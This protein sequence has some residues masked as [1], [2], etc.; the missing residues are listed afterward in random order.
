MDKKLLL[1]ISLY[2]V[3]QAF[4]FHELGI[5]GEVAM[6]WGETPDVW[7]EIDPVVWG[8][9]ANSPSSG[10][11][12]GPF[13]AN[14]TRPQEQLRLGSYTLPLAMNQY[15]GG[16]WDWP[17]RIVYSI[18]PSPMA[19]RIFHILLGGVFIG[20]IAWLFKRERQN[21][22]AYGCALVLATDWSFTFYKQALGGTEIAL[23][24]AIAGLLWV[25]LYRKS[26]FYFLLFLGVGFHAKFPFLFA[27][28]PLLFWMLIFKRW[29]SKDGFQ[30]GLLAFLV[31]L[32]PLLIS[33][34]HH[35]QLNGHIRSHDTF[36]MQWKRVQAAFSFSSQ[37]SI[38]ENSSNL[39]LWLGAPMQFYEQIYDLKPQAWLGSWIRL[40]TLA[41]LSLVVPFFRRNNDLVFCTAVLISQLLLI[42]V[43]A[44]DMHHFAMVLPVFAV[45]LGLLLQSLWT[46]KPWLILCV[47]P[48]T[49]ASSSDMLRSD[50][51]FSQIL[52]PTF[53]SH[54]Q[55][56]L[57]EL[58]RSHNVERLITMDYEIYGLIEH[59]APEI[60]SIHAWGVISHKRKR[61]LAG[62]LS[63][64]NGGHLIV[65]MPS[66]PMIYNLRPSGVQLQKEGKELG[67][68]VTEIDSWDDRLWLYR[69]DT[70]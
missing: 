18:Y 42:A 9:A 66:M 26:L 57:Q 6:G 10:S 59:I 2:L 61:A 14:E 64:A 12:W 34:I 25:V 47:L 29:P 49:L 15:T 62:I 67:L 31:L 5:V 7:S 16:V 22:V 13:I 24:V 11:V 23:Q 68:R 17:S 30:K 50:A 51:T 48:I 54:D 28:L 46:Y 36:S 58:L 65:L 60:E 70:L 35:G 38:R 27:V 40:P 39:L 55:R 20:W 4:S 53:R 37:A 69:V 32:S 21:I 45:T 3:L 41:L 19:V 52:V 33:W 56:A 43:A 63:E 8:N 1:I 44:K